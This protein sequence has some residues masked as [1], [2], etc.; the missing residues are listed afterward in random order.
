MIKKSK[1]I[2]VTA[3]SSSLFLILLFNIFFYFFKPT[4]PF[5]FL[6]LNVLISISLCIF[7]LKILTSSI[8]AHIKNLNDKL[9]E[10]TTKLSHIDFNKENISKPEEIENLI[11]NINSFI[12]EY[13]EKIK[14]DASNHILS[15]IRKETKILEAYDFNKDEKLL[16]S[17][18]DSSRK[19]IMYLDATLGCSSVESEKISEAVIV[20]TQSIKAVSETI[21][22]INKIASSFEETEFSISSLCKRTNEIKNLITDIEAQIELANHLALNSAIEAAR[23]GENGRGFAVISNEIKKM[24]EKI[25]LTTKEITKEIDITM[26]EIQSAVDRLDSGNKKVENGIVLGNNAAKSMLKLV[27]LIDSVNNSSSEISEKIQSGMGMLENLSNLSA[28]GKRYKT[29]IEHL[30]KTISNILRKTLNNDDKTKNNKKEENIISFNSIND[31][32]AQI[33]ANQLKSDYKNK[34]FTL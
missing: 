4:S 8:F 25:S 5:L 26:E 28:I 24:A 34:Q 27:D 18:N 32:Q 29:N 11:K 9:K 2:I 13:G 6:I 12:S 30:K 33:G 23:A 15:E 3:F 19:V 10:K 17:I 22:G 21:D 31:G 14:I 20:A 7:L 1:I 16:S